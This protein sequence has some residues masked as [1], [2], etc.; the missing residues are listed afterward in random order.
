MLD[1]EAG[2]PLE[3]FLKKGAP[4]ERARIDVAFSGADFSEE[5]EQK[6]CQLPTRKLAAFLEL[7]CPDAAVLIPY[8]SRICEINEKLVVRCYPV[9]GN[10]LLLMKCTGAAK[11]PTL[12]VFDGEGNEKKGA[13]VE[14]P[15]VLRERLAREEGEARRE[16]LR[17]FRQGRC[18]NLIEEDL[19]RIL[20]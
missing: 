1:L 20:G 2:I 3:N 9:K 12:L 6:I 4:E 19:L 8:L 17:D 15:A 16:L 14:H 5:F 18:G 13:Y 10:E 7:F 11:I